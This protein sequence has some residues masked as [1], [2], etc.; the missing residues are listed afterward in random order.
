MLIPIDFGESVLWTGT[1][2]FASSTIRNVA[3]YPTYAGY[4]AFIAP[5]FVTFLTQFVS[6]TPML[7]K[8]NDKELGK[9]C[10]F[11]NNKN[12]DTDL[13]RARL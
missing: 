11:I 12:I 10:M 6:G 2:I 9:E 4:L 7:E 13:I 5:A 8:K 3:F 1:A